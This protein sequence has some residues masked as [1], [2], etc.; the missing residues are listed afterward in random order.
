MSKNF[1]AQDGT[2]TAITGGIVNFDS[3]IVPAVDGSLTPIATDFTASDPTANTAGA[4]TSPYST[5]YLLRW[6]VKGLQGLFAKFS[7]G[8]ALSD[9]DANPTTTSVGAKG[10][11]WDGSQWIRS[12]QAVTGSI[13]APLV[14]IANTIGLGRYNA[15]PFTL[16][17]LEYRA[18]QL[19]KNAELITSEIDILGSLTSI[20]AADSGST[21]VTG[22][23]GQSIVTGTPTAGSVVSIAPTG[24]S[25]FSARVS[26][27]FVGTLQFE[28][29]VDGV[30]WNPIVADVA[31]L[32][33]NTSQITSIGSFHGNASSCIGVRVRCLTLTSGS[34]SVQLMTGS[35]V[36]TIKIGNPL[37]LFDAVSG[38]LATI[39]AASTPATAT[40]TAIVVDV[41][42]YPLPITQTVSIASGTSLSNGFALNSAFPVALNVPAVWTTANI[43]FQ[44]SLD[45]GVTYGNART[46]G[47]SEV[48]I[49][50]STAGDIYSLNPLDFA[51]FT[52]LKI[53]SG[54]A[55]T[56]I[57]QVS[58][59]SLVLSTR[60]AL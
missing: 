52:H 21:T 25:T 44:G 36:N 51:A 14:G 23:N 7:A 17:D 16:G 40:D 49:N 13:T 28:R 53:R 48:T 56:P 4:S 18:F 19:S 54:I 12:R 15:T 1:A 59:A 39:K 38:M 42:N 58:A 35:G 46:S 41:R 34:P 43:T 45:G 47:G 11:L 32:N 6:I 24:D 27:T 2:G 10:Q 5:P 26:G 29:T 60:G 57:S 8:V 30:S 55:A 31:G 33:F 9:T 37:R 50:V 3:S 22:Q 20:T